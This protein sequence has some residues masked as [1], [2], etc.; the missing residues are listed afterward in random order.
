MK[1]IIEKELYISINKLDGLV[2]VGTIKFAKE[3]IKSETDF[4]SVLQKVMKDLDNGTYTVHDNN[5]LFARFDLN[6]QSIRLHKWSENT[7]IV[8][9]CWNYFQ[10]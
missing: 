10:E 5:S 6:K 9:P 3:D 4:I 8:M 7:G 2:R 1:S